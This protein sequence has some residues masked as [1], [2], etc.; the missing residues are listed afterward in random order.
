MRLRDRMPANVYEGF[1]DTK[2][3]GSN[4]FMGRYEDQYNELKKRKENKDKEFN[5]GG[6][7]QKL[8]NQAKGEFKQYVES[9]G[10]DVG[11][12]STQKQLDEELTKYDENILFPLV[13]LRKEI[14]NSTDINAKMSELTE[15]S[16]KL[17][18]KKL[19]LEAAKEAYSTAQVRDK[20]LTTR[21]ELVSY[22]QTWG[23]MQR[24]IKK[25]TVPVLIV[26]TLL[27]LYLG[28]LGIYYISPVPALATTAIGSTGSFDMSFVGNIGE[29]FG[30]S[31]VLIALIQGGAVIGVLLIILKALGRI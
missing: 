12:A 29:F 10:R 1:E 27:F 8:L 17:N 6:S 24:P 18:A 23:L 15:I 30:Q 31:P 14:I 4:P 5:S 16:N 20:V 3:Q 13:N 19:D 9:S 11:F 21:N 22:Q 26:F 25:Q 2:N 7:L 28:V